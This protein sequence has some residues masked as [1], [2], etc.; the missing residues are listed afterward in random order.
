MAAASSVRDIENFMGS[1]P[2]LVSRAYFPPWAARLS[3][4]A[5]PKP[6]HEVIK[7]ERGFLPSLSSV[8]VS[9]LL[10]RRNRLS[11]RALITLRRNL[12]RRMDDVDLRELHIPSRR[13]GR[14]AA[15][16]V[17]S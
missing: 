5:A 7:K 11:R 14:V 13:D 10:A 12:L 4:R 15:I 1:S 9:S 17:R 16:G 8:T 3:R 6:T 2:G